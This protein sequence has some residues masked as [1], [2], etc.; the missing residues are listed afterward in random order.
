MQILS[1]ALNGDVLRHWVVGEGD[2]GI[3]QPVL[4]SSGS[5]ENCYVYTGL[6]L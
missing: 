3:V 2:R 1:A 5:G 4:F 6:P